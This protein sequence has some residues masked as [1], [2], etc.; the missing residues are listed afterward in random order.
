MP[1]LDSQLHFLA[2]RN[3]G[4]AITSLFWPVDCMKIGR[5]VAPLSGTSAYFLF[6]GVYVPSSNDELHDALS[7]FIH[8]SG[9]Q[10]SFHPINFGFIG[11]PKGRNR[12]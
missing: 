8:I 2:N 3:A 7:R 1:V 11:Y 5:L 12:I 4:L 10:I 6:P 9:S